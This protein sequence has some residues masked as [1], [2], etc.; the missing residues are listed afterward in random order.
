MS[1]LQHYVV[2][3][4]DNFIQEDN[5]DI[6]KDVSG[7]DLDTQIKSVTFTNRESG[8][9]ITFNN[10]IVIQNL[11]WKDKG[12]VNETKN[13]S[14]GFGLPDDLK[15]PKVRVATSSDGI[16]TAPTKVIFDP[17]F[18]AV[19]QE[20]IHRSVNKSAFKLL[21][22][23]QETSPFTASTAV[24]TDTMKVYIFLILDNTS[25]AFTNA[26]VFSEFVR[27]FLQTGTMNWVRITKDD[28]SNKP[29]G[30][31][32]Y[33]GVAGTPYPQVKGSNPTNHDSIVGVWEFKFAPTLDG[34]IEGFT[35]VEGQLKNGKYYKMS[36]VPLAA[37]STQT[38][39]NNHE[40]SVNIGLAQKGAIAIYQVA[41][42]A[43]DKNDFIYIRMLKST[44]RI[45][46]VET[47]DFNIEQQILD[48]QAGQGLISN[49]N[50]QHLNPGDT[51]EVK[52]GNQVS[53]QSPV[54]QTGLATPLSYM[55]DVVLGQT[56]PLGTTGFLM[57]F[58]KEAQWDT[59]AHTS[60]NADT[61][62]SG[63]TGNYTF[64]HPVIIKQ[65]VTMSSAVTALV[66]T[67]INNPS[68]DPAKDILFSE[69]KDC[70][71]FTL[72]DLSNVLNNGSTSTEGWS[73]TD[74]D[75]MLRYPTT[76]EYLGLDKS[77]K[78]YR[79]ALEYKRDYGTGY[80]SFN[81]LMAAIKAYYKEVK[82][83]DMPQER[84]TIYTNL[85][86]N[87]WGSAT[88]YKTPFKLKLIQC[89]YSKEVITL[90]GCTS[91]V[92]FMS[93]YYLMWSRPGD[94]IKTTTRTLPV[95]AEI[96]G[97]NV[98]PASE[99]VADIGNLVLTASPIT[100]VDADLQYARVWKDI[101]GQEHLKSD[102]VPDLYSIENLHSEIYPN[103]APYLDQALDPDLIDICYGRIKKD[104]MPIGAWRFFYLTPM[105]WAVEGSTIKRVFWEKGENFDKY[106]SAEESNNPDFNC[107]TVSFSTIEGVIDP[108]YWENPEHEKIYCSVYFCAEAENGKTSKIEF[109][110]ELVKPVVLGTLVRTHKKSGITNDMWA[111]TTDTPA[112]AGQHWFKRYINKTYDEL[113]ELD[114]IDEM[115]GF[116]YKTGLGTVTPRF[117][118]YKGQEDKV[119]ELPVLHYPYRVFTDGSN[120]GTSDTEVTLKGS[121]GENHTIKIP[122][123]GQGDV[124][125][126]YTGMYNTSWPITTAQKELV[127]GAGNL[128]SPE[129]TMSEV[130]PI[131]DFGKATYTRQRVKVG[132]HDTI[133]NN[134]HVRIGFF[135]PIQ[136][137]QWETTSKTYRHDPGLYSASAAIFD[138]TD[139]KINESI[140]NTAMYYTPGCQIIPG[141]WLWY[142]T[143]YIPVKGKEGTATISITRVQLESQDGW[144]ESWLT[145]NSKWQVLACIP[146]EHTGNLKYSFNT[147]QSKFVSDISS[148]ISYV[149]NDTEGLNSVDATG[150]A[151][152]LEMSAK[153]PLFEPWFER[154]YKYL[155]APDNE[156][157]ECYWDIH[158]KHHA[159]RNQQSEFILF[160]EQGN[161]VGKNY[162]SPTVDAVS[163]GT[164][165]QWST[166]ADRL[167]E[168]GNGGL[169]TDTMYP[170]ASRNYRTMN[171]VEG[172]QEIPKQA[173]IYDKENKR[174]L[175]PRSPFTKWLN[176]EQGLPFARDYRRMV[177]M[178]KLKEYNTIDELN[179]SWAFSDSLNYKL[180]V[181]KEDGQPPKLKRFTD[182]REWNSRK[183]FMY[184]VFF[185]T[186]RCHIMDIEWTTTDIK[187][188][189][190]CRYRLE[191]VSMSEF[192]VTPDKIIKALRGNNSTE[193]VQEIRTFELEATRFWNNTTGNWLPE[194]LSRFIIGSAKL[195]NPTY[196]TTQNGQV[197]STGE[198]TPGE[199]K[200]VGQ[201]IPVRSVLHRA[202]TTIRNK[203]LNRKVGE[204]PPFITQEGEA[205]EIQT[206]NGYW[207]GAYQS[208]I[209]SGVDGY[210]TERNFYAD[211][212]EFQV[213]NHN[214]TGY[215]YQACKN[216]QT[217][218]HRKPELVSTGGAPATYQS[219]RPPYVLR[220]WGDFHA[221]SFEPG[222]IWRFFNSNYAQDLTNT[223][224]N[225]MWFENN[226]IYDLELYLYHIEMMGNIGNVGWMYNQNGG[227]GRW[228]GNDQGGGAI[229]QL[230]TTAGTRD[231]APYGAGANDTYNFN[232]VG[233]GSTEYG[234]NYAIQKYQYKYGSVKHHSHPSID[235]R[236][237]NYTCDSFSI[238]QGILSSDGSGRR[239]GYLP[240]N[241]DGPVTCLYR[242]G[243][244]M[245]KLAGGAYSTTEKSFFK[246]C[247][248]KVYAPYGYDMWSI[249][250]STSE[251]SRGYNPDNNPRISVVI[252][253]TSRI[254]EWQN[255]G[256]K[257]PGNNSGVRNNTTMN[258]SNGHN[259]TTNYDN[260][261]YLREACGL[262]ILTGG[263][264]K[265]EGSVSIPNP[266]W[267]GNP[268][269]GQF[270]TGAAG[271]KADFSRERIIAHHNIYQCQYYGAIPKSFRLSFTSAPSALSFSLSLSQ[272]APTRTTISPITRESEL[273]KKNLS[274]S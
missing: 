61:S 99:Y 129:A 193:V 95:D 222:V 271:Y 149:I 110:F 238:A 87:I 145:D 101:D 236:Y 195:P 11:E 253:D 177:L 22:A 191:A 148:A 6:T 190:Q 9:P 123:Y 172:F 20:K 33:R 154:A 112:T 81:N 89:F 118:A 31:P 162:M 113:K 1:E 78:D 36:M 168:G 153:K 85:F 164:Y 159:L 207:M 250:C 251:G 263:N 74:I 19:N 66:G 204:A 126:G 243:E 273:E 247:W 235:Y 186:P 136:Y 17:A 104:K 65:R 107:K 68:K 125:D 205:F 248:F 166:G 242:G 197:T 109:R 221:V 210:D 13:V 209:R 274:I 214:A 179:D 138:I 239:Q 54:F 76:L 16:S 96:S 132:V 63:R 171:Q 155:N 262:A 208:Q 218:R 32:G 2:K 49:Q 50:L 27:P 124:P 270:G 258:Y 44:D 70:L 3:Y 143:I 189:C 225:S 62:V 233:T 120:G 254:N 230:V 269:A 130:L 100:D 183:D 82:K 245:I 163:N 237:S 111:Y 53:D 170:C 5:I 201:N 227:Y 147:N 45:Q 180:E 4:K 229:P 119:I 211:P 51:D 38:D 67:D 57:K 43:E 121:D 178:K 173:I 192:I 115:Q 257:I 241:M 77:S 240:E 8:L 150:L 174:Y 108:E 106:L 246:N 97:Q 264:A 133:N 188:N 105:V 73:G 46:T 90:K 40:D 216:L 30:K 212:S 256:Q 37:L 80:Y 88:T 167:W 200:Q 131:L 231:K 198:T 259:G 26:Q 60:V 14:D 58:Q 194:G 86:Q 135:C 94:I 182:G 255:L 69:A 272:S 15:L 47:P 29:N 152:T 98:S 122:K 156:K 59:Q 42:T 35:E 223:N 215:N 202:F 260:Y 267:Y 203:K 232:G 18:I 244:Q 116:Y 114:L 141:K 181:P 158:N 252:A 187:N 175:L 83:T 12:Y 10:G 102:L 228:P 169:N 24:G 128:S 21:E 165:N 224:L 268:V 160:D 137:C 226:Q 199:V 34:V 7:E 140:G 75:N 261:V 249:H 134:P 213:G 55:F 185:Y 265:L 266:C 56:E 23:V 139:P 41:D 217:L 64:T 146:T 84:V 92:N 220:A 71:A 219:G 127:I 103:G 72:A 93:P 52:V 28:A 117:I 234:R 151:K 157:F 196:V 144:D 184:D 91:N 161:K 39:T 79:D 142:E 176:N 25:G 48:T 206:V